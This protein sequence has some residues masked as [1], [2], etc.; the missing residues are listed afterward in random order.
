MAWITGEITPAVARERGWVTWD[1]VLTNWS[2]FGGAADTNS[3]LFPTNAAQLIIPSAFGVAIGGSSDIDRCRIQ[4]NVNTG[5]QNIISNFCTFDS[6]TQKYLSVGSPIIYP[7]SGPLTIFADC[8][9]DTNS[10]FVADDGSSTAT[11]LNT[12]ANII[13]PALHLSFFLQQ[14]AVLPLDRNPGYSAAGGTTT[15]AF[16]LFKIIPIM[17]RRQ[18]RIMIHQITNSADYRFGL[19][20][21]TGSGGGT[22]IEAIVQTAG[23]IP[24]NDVQTFVFTNLANAMYL[25]IWAETKDGGGGGSTFEWVS[26]FTDRA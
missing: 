24:A 19:I 16:Q 1:V 9:E 6:R 22:N 5:L 8:G 14:S 23:G 25:T 10:T 4:F 20:S 3:R 12:N 13:A 7:L 15:N 21:S 11:A 18:G 17:G 2:F 26:E